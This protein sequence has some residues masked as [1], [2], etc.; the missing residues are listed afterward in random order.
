MGRKERIQR[1]RTRGG[2]A[3]L[4]R[5]EVLVPASER[6]HILAEAARLREIHRSGTIAANARTNYSREEVLIRLAPRYLWWTLDGPE[7]ER[8]RR[9]LAQIMNLGTYEDIRAIE[10]AFDR[11]ELVAVLAHAEPGWFSPRSWEFWRGRLG[12]SAEPGLS[13]NPPRR[14]F[15]AEVL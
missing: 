5:V 2:A 13:A 14:S 6:S 15:H 8:T 10:A 11:E 1:Y 12:L 9:T 3:D 4:V 7:D